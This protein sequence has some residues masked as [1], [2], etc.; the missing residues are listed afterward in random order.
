MNESFCGSLGISYVVVIEIGAFVEARGRLLLG[1]FDGRLPLTY[2]Y[3]WTLNAFLQVGGLVLLGSGRLHQRF[4]WRSRIV[5][6]LSCID[7]LQ[8]IARGKL[9]SGAILRPFLLNF[10]PS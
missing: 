3:N 8:L 2:L 10:V 1:D 9:N 4:G 5:K 6:F 7:F